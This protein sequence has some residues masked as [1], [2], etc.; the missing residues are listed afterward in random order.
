MIYIICSKMKTWGRWWKW[1]WS[2]EKKWSAV[3]PWWCCWCW[4][5]WWYQICDTN[6]GLQLLPLQGVGPTNLAALNQRCLMLA[7]SIPSGQLTNHRLKPAFPTSLNLK[8]LIPIPIPFLVKCL[9]IN[10]LLSVVECLW[11]LLILIFADRLCCQSFLE[12]P[13]FCRG[14]VFAQNLSV[15]K[16]DQEKG[17]NF[18]V[19]AI[20]MQ[21]S[22]SQ[23]RNRWKF[24]K[25]TRYRICG[26]IFS[27]K[28]AHVFERTRDSGCQR[29]SYVI[30]LLWW[31]KHLM[32]LGSCNKLL[33]SW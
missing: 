14:P 24:N 12:I 26:G 13:S 21:W 29:I 25:N 15:W 28:R 11:F 27:T 4:Y 23:I 19:I 18:A 10:L 33:S 3:S 22:P 5:W 17:Y 8:C 2:A 9:L 6:H 7:D 20:L 30:H 16:T 31:A 1:S 32:T